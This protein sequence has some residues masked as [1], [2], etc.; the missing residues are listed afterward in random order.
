MNKRAYILILILSIAV[1]SFSQK[2]TSEH[3]LK[4]ITGLAIG[5]K[6]QTPEQVKQ[7]AINEAKVNALKKAGI[8]ES[9]NSYSDYLRSETENSYE[10]L[11]TSDILSN[12][13]GTVKD[14]E[15][16]EDK[17]SFTPESQLRCDVKINCT[18][19]KYK[20][21][22]DI[23]F[24]AWIENIDPV[25]RYGD[26]LSFTVKPTQ[27]CY[28]RAFMFAKES[29]VLLPNDYERSH[30][31]TAHTTYTFPD[32]ELIEYY[33]MIIED[34]T[35]DRETNRLVILLLKENLYYTDDINYKD[36][37]DWIMSIPPDE[38][39]IESFAFEV[40]RDK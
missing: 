36:I 39:M 21:K 22:K 32:P 7:K 13:N 20:T 37:T 33:E 2:K 29:Y 40:F 34:N 25:Y 3:K 17:M 10:E 24:E 4:S 16:I 18:V 12:I 14:I 31:L 5:G 8:T 38:R 19:V 11:F 15:V 35:I 9:I 28:L 1:S 30:L 6:S 23:S 26:G 27:N